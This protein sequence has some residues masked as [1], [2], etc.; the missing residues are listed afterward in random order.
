MPDDAPSTADIRAAPPHRT[1][2]IIWVVILMTL[3]AVAYLVWSRSGKEVA[4]KAPGRNKESSKGKKGREDAPT[5]V[6]GTRARRGNIG[7]YVTGLGTVVPL[8]TVLVKTRVDGEL[9]SVKYREGDMVQKGDL[10]M[11]IDPRPFQVALEQAEGQLAKDQAALE[12]ARV[13]LARYQQLVAQRA[14]PEQQLATQKATVAQDEG[15]IKS[16][17]AQID[18]AKLNLTYSRIVAP[19]SGRIGLRLVDAGNIVHAADSTGLVVI[20]QMQP[21]TVV[22]TIAEDQLPA[23]LAK[24]KAGQ[25]L[26]VDSYDRQMQNKI[27]QGTLSTPDN[28][29]DPTTGTIRM[30]ATFENKD[31]K[32]FPN[33]FVN[34]RLLVEEKHGVVLVPAAVLQRGSNSTFVYLVNPDSSVAVR[35]VT[36]GVTEGDD[37][38]I[39]SGLDAGNVVVLTGADKLQEGGKVD[40]Q[41][42]GEAPAIPQAAGARGN[43]PKGN[44]AKGKKP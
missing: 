15:V 32:L 44:G 4:A 5:P 43:A 39:T 28:E 23:V 42:P 38:E 3:S 6:V 21:T 2:W 8:S 9:I 33:Q 36:V 13:D 35:N 25:N 11:E 24:M 12:N 34:A 41:V 7:V 20:T 10:L 18:S 26:T 17:Q 19:N 40:A 37:A 31:Q 30:R 27:A 14:V 16:D 22:F 29:I 1:R